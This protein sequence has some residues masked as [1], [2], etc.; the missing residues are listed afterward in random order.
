[1]KSYFAFILLMIF[2]LGFCQSKTVSFDSKS[3][4]ISSTL[5]DHKEQDSIKIVTIE[6]LGKLPSNDFF[7]SDNVNLLPKNYNWN[8]DIRRTESFK[9]MALNNKRQDF[10]G[11]DLPIN[12]HTEVTQNI[13]LKS[14]SYP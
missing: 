12:I 14:I 4:I 13:Y 5:F 3:T 2:S 8:L 9:S 11:R 6:M 10:C 1:M 7:E